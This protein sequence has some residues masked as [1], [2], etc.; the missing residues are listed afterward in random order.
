MAIP[1]T[2]GNIPAPAKA[3]RDRAGPVAVGRFVA[4]IAGKALSRGG[5]VMAGLISQWAA[6]SGPSLAAY[7]L[8]AKLVRAAPEPDFP[9]KTAASLLHLKVDPAKALEVQYAIPQIVERINQA[10][11][12]KAVEG[13]R[14]IQAPIHNRPRVAVAK[15]QTGTE[16][17]ATNDKASRLEKALARM[18]AGVKCRG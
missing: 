8:P 18:A 11:G 1:S 16:S 12:Y 14:V 7:T 15:A 4:P 2:H 3:V 5:P 6:I 13:I 9:E 10:L 17:P